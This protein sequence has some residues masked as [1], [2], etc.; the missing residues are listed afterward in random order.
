MFDHVI[1]I[2]KV[3]EER[4]AEGEQSR[5]AETYKATTPFYAP[6]TDLRQI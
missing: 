4:V 5:G 3:N 6:D 2:V 1:D